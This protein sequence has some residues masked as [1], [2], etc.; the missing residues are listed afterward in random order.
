[1]SRGEV[2]PIYQFG[3]GV[4]EGD[5]PHDHAIRRIRVPGYA[6]PIELDVDDPYPGNAGSVTRSVNRRGAA[7]RATGASAVLSISASQRVPASVPPRFLEHRRSRARHRLT[8]NHSSASLRCAAGRCRLTSAI[9][10]S[11]NASASHE[12]AARRVDRLHVVEHAH[13]HFVRP[14]RARGHSVRDGSGSHRSAIARHRAVVSKSP[15]SGSISTPSALNRKCPGKLMPC[16]VMPD[17]RA[18]HQIRNAERDR[19]APTR[20]QN[21]CRCGS[22]RGSAG[23]RWP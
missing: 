9:W 22:H 16:V 17:A 20:T 12:V 23:C 3:E 4:L 14:T 8:G 11:I 10:L 2:A 13:G 6:H 5:G 19:N 18:D 7:D 15:V 21:T 1:M